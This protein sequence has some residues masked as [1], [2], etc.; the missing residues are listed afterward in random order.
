MLKRFNVCLLGPGDLSQIP[1]NIHMLEDGNPGYPST[2]TRNLGVYFF[3][4]YAK[5]DNHIKEMSEKIYELMMYVN[6]IKKII[7]M[8]VVESV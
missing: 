8:K 4:P 7:S 2:S 3:N 6:R 1:A 5:F